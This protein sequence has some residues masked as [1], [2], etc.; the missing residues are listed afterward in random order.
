MASRPDSRIRFG[1]LRKTAVRAVFRL[2]GNGWDCILDYDFAFQ[3]FSST[4]AKHPMHKLLITGGKPLSGTVKISGAKNAA[5]KMIISCLLT[6]NEVTLDNVPL[7]AETDI[8][9]ELVT[10]LG[11]QTELADHTLKISVPKIAGTSAMQL[12][13]KNRLAILALAPLLHRAGEAYVPMLGGDKIAS[14]GA[15]PRRCRSPRHRL[16]P[17]GPSN[18]WPAS[19]AGG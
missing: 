10:M 5:S 11:A 13:R 9:R 1:D 15:R 19:A 17:R 12:S 6:D 7:Q 2:S 16:R 4:I 14:A 8:A 3:V 18:R